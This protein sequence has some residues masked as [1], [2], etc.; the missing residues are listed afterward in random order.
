L[1]GISAA[2]TNDPDIQNW[3]N[4][5][6][7]E[8]RNYHGEQLVSRQTTDGQWRIVILEVRAAD[9]IT[10]YH[11]IMGHVDSSQ[12]Y[13]SIRSIFWFPHMCRRIDAYVHSCDTCQRY[14]DAGQG[15]GEL[16]PR[17]D[18]SV[19]FE[20]V[21]VNLVGPWS[22]NIEGNTLEIQALTIIDIATTLSEAVCIEDK[23]SQHISNLFENNWLARYPRL[24]RV[25]F[26]QGGEFV[27]RPFQSMLI[28]NGIRPAATTTKNPQSNAVCER[29]HRTIKDSLR[30]ICHSN[31][32]QNVATAIKLVESVL[33]SA[34]YASRTAVHRTLGISPGALVFGRDMLLPIPVLHDYN[35]I[36]ER[37]QTLID[38]NA[39]TQNRRRYFKDYLVGDEILI[40]VPNPAGLDPQPLDLRIFLQYLTIS[41]TLA[42]C[43]FSVF[44]TKK[45]NTF[46]NVN[47]LRTRTSDQLEV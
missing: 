39:A 41:G 25:I 17:E 35:L 22:I 20:E 14:K 2:Q 36:R 13:N 11:H 18:T 31:P 1:Y 30:T 21:T 29:M 15:Q 16:P 45:K 44:L 32:P 6:S 23:S 9:T 10:W 43:Y 4:L 34:S 24:V 38:R 26:D 3:L 37:R 42:Y 28:H 8:L 5:P 12:E 47:I 7:F 27:G 46:D 19:P 33:A 40:R